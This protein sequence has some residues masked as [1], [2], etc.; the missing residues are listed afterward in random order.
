MWKRIFCTIAICF[1][2]VCVVAQTQTASPPPTVIHLPPP[3]VLEPVHALRLSDLIQMTLERNPRLAQASFAIDAAR[4]RAHQAGLYPNPTVTVSDEELGDRTGPGGI[5]TAP[6]VTQEIVTANKLGLSR[7]AAFREVDQ[8]TLSLAAERFS[9]F[10]AVRQSYFEVLTLQRRTAILGELVKLAEESVDTTRKLL[11]AKQVARLDLLQLEIELERFRA[12]RD[13]TQRELPAAFRRLAASVGVSDLPETLVV[14]TLEVP[15]PDYDLEKARQYMLAVHPEALSAQVGVERAQLLLK[16]AE[17]EP[18][19]NVTVG[20]SYIRQYE[21][22]SHDLGISVSLPVPVWNRNQ[23]NI[24]A[25]QAEV[26]EAIQRVGRVE[27]DLTGRLATAFGTYA[28]ARQRAERYRTAILPK[29]RE[30]YQLSLKAYQGGQFEYLRVL[31]AQRSL[32]E[33]NLDYIRSLGELWR[34]ASDIAGLLLEEVWP[35]APVAPPTPHLR[36]EEK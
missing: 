22:R 31:Q 3:R 36:P 14:G 13:A 26:G 8:A 2:P 19:P 1:L 34:S 10:T 35:C 11:E 12:E 18:I 6:A 5:L 30:T 16:R 4:G 29:A 15:A 20:A 23:G 32:A 24:R 25:A 17:A 9:R 7:A 33:A 21:N 27:N 28:A